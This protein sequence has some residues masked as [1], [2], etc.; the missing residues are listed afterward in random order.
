MKSASQKSRGR[1]AIPAKWSRIIDMDNLDA[2]TVKGF[3]IEDD[4]DTGVNHALPASRRGL[5]R[6]EP[7]FFAKDFWEQSY[8]RSLEKNKLSKRHLKLQAKVVI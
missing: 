8:D 4:K 2:Y 1:K 7:L 5:Q 6:W 3:S